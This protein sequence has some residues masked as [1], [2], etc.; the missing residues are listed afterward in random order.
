MAGA[1]RFYVNELRTLSEKVLN[2]AW[3]L[4]S[5]RVRFSLALAANATPATVAMIEL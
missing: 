3:F 4:A 2:D 5:M 1:G